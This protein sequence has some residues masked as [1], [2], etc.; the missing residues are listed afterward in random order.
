MAQRRS[1][2]RLLATTLTSLAGAAALA[3][4]AFA[5]DLPGAVADEAPLRV[6][7]PGSPAALG[8][9][10]AKL[11]EKRRRAIAARK[12]ELQPDGPFVPVVGQPDY[13]TA[14]NAFGAARSGHS[15]AGH[16][17]F[18]N[19]GTPVVAVADGSVVDA[20]SDGGQGNFVHVYDP[21]AGQTYI[22]MHLIEPASVKTGDQV[23]AGEGLGGVGCTGSCWGDH[24]HFEIRAGKSMAGKAHDP[25]PELRRWKALDEPL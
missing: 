17:M 3:I 12:R 20:G 7:T 18:A 2:T 23:K 10:R 15:H 13:G 19:P 11:A 1:S 14:A 8:E 5:A 21:E 16:D 4:P 9:A 24:L 6:L 25:L 22:Y